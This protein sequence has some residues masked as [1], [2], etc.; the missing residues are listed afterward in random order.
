MTGTGCLLLE[1]KV[2]VVTGAAA[3]I[4][5][6]AAQVFSAHGARLVLADIDAEGG[7]GTVALVEQNG[8]KAV[9]LS[10]DVTVADQVDAMVE[11]AMRTFGRL[12]CAFNNVGIDGDSAPLAESTDSNWQR[13]TDVNLT[14]TYLCMR[15][16]LR[17][18]AV[19]QAGS[20]VNTSSIAGLVG[21]NMGLSAYTAAKHGVVGL[22]KAAALEYADKNIRV[23]AVCPGAVRTA[24]LDHA[25]RS[26]ALT[27]EQ[28]RGLQPLGRL[29][30]PHEIAQAA[31][32]LCSDHASFVTG[33][34]MPVDGGATCG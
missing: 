1:G 8:G 26:G 6:A 24:L 21:V 29:G 31:A 7:E 3:G 13:V 34:A 16:E 20:V 4:G 27:E 18:M 2:A 19:Q 32:W 11:A 10:T 14:G 9:F 23:N 17:V 28:A 30:A 12:D 15:A 25:I 33:I 22:T 5:R